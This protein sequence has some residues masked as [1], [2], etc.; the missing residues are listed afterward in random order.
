MGIFSDNKQETKII[1]NLST[2]ATDGHAL[3]VTTEPIKDK[4]QMRRHLLSGYPRD[5]NESRKDYEE[6]LKREF[7]LPVHEG[8]LLI[9]PQWSEYKPILIVLPNNI[10]DLPKGLD[11]YFREALEYIILK[12][13]TEQTIKEMLWKGITERDEILKQVAG[14][15]FFKDIEKLK[16]KIVDD[17][18][19]S[20]KREQT[21][22]TIPE[23]KEA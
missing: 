9:N 5:Y 22:T 23:K 7:N 1:L 21:P 11:M 2:F 4:M 6:K 19:K 13:N 17:A 14:L 20:F 16:G 12:K 15:E 18:F 10:Q 8:F 3:L